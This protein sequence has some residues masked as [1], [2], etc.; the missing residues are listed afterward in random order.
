MPSNR[1]LPLIAMYLVSHYLHCPSF[2]TT[3][4]TSGCTIRC[5]NSLGW[6]VKFTLQQ[7]MNAQQKQ[8]DSF[9][10]SSTSALDGSG[11][12]TPTPRPLYAQEWVGTHCIEVRVSPGT[13]VDGCGKSRP[14]RDS[15][16]WPCSP[17][18][19]P[20]TDYAIPAH[21]FLGFWY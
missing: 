16:P 10:I 18:A 6:N 15:I 4:S 8:I 14:H 21:S 7:A 12:L 5:M 20:Y 13:G 2:D 3:H 11:R 1:P 19:S 9:T 17:V